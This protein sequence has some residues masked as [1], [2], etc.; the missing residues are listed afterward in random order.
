MCNDDEGGLKTGGKNTDVW[1]DMVYAFGNLGGHTRSV[2]LV[3][4]INWRRFYG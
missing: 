1:G 4:L 2:N 3:L